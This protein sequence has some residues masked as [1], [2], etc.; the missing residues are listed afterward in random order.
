M[1]DRLESILQHYKLN[2]SKLA[3]MIDVQRSGISHILSGR[4]NPSY[5]FLVSILDAFPEINANWLLT[6]NG[7]MIEISEGTSLDGMAD[8]K[9]ITPVSTEKT[10]EEGKSQLRQNDL[11]LS[12]DKEGYKSK[13]NDNSQRSLEKV[14]ILYS[15][16]KFKEY[17][18]E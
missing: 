15:D 2:S 6:G 4:N 12:T 13:Q 10:I 5:D 3:E 1:K 14:I 16:G 17:R 18:Q 11:H 7:N 8:L 9:N